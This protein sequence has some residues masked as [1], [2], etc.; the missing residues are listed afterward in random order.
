MD[1]I[2]VIAID[3]FHNVFKVMDVASANAYSK[4]KAISFT[5]FFQY[6]ISIAGIPFAYISCC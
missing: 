4:I 2:W 3:Q 6:M 5:C 1:I